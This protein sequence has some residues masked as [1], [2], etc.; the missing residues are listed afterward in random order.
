[1]PPL[2]HCRLSMPPRSHTGENNQSP[3]VRVHPVPGVP[4]ISLGQP[5]GLLDKA[6]RSPGVG[7]IMKE[8]P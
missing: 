7:P 4:E 3:P 5:G 8:P 1:M 2:A 6:S